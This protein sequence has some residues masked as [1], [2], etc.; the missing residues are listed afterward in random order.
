MS[1]PLKTTNA[2]GGKSIVKIS[3]RFMQ[4]LSKLHMKQTNNQMLLI[5]TKRLTNF[6]LLRNL[7]V[8]SSI[9]RKLQVTEAT[10]LARYFIA[11]L[12]PSNQRLGLAQALP[13]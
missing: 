3:N 12:A 9:Q 2:I 8:T 7:P 11:G 5:I 10:I 6:H 1:G 4:W 13:T